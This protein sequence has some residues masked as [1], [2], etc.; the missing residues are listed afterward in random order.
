ME[1]IDKE[2]TEPKWMLIVWPKILQ[3]P[4]NLSAQFAVQ[5]QQFGISVKK[6]FIG[7]R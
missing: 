5:A 1:N 3:K 6:G 4:Q 7:R 2:L